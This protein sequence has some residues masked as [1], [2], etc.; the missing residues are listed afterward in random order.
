MIKIN[1][2]GAAGA[3]IMLL[4]VAYLSVSHYVVMYADNKAYQEIEEQA[5]L[6]IELANQTITEYCGVTPEE[7]REEFRKM[8]ILLY[9]EY[10]HCRSYWDQG[11]FYGEE[12][13]CSDDF[14]GERLQAFFNL[15]DN[16]QCK[17]VVPEE[18]TLPYE[19]LW[20][21]YLE[22]PMH[23]DCERTVF[24][25]LIEYDTLGNFAYQ[26][27][28]R[29]IIPS[30][31]CLTYTID[32]KFYDRIISKINPQDNWKDYLKVNSSTNFDNADI[33]VFSE[34]D[35][36]GNIGVLGDCKAHNWGKK[37]ILNFSPVM[38]S[39]LKEVPGDYK[40]I[41]KP[42]T[43]NPFEITTSLS[44]STYYHFSTKK[45]DNFT[46]D[47]V[48]PECQYIFNLD[49]YNNDVSIDIS[50]NPYQTQTN[51]S[52]DPFA[53]TSNVELTYTVNNNNNEA[54]ENVDVEII[55]NDKKIK[56]T[57]DK[58]EAN[59]NY[60]ITELA[61]IQDG[62]IA[63]TRAYTKSMKSEINISNNIEEAYFSSKAGQINFAPEI[64]VEDKIFI[65]A[66]ELA[67]I[68]PFIKDK[69][70]DT[71][72]ISYSSLFNENGEWQTTENDAGTYEIEITASDG[73]L[74]NKKSL[75]VSV[76]DFDKVK[77]IEK[78][79]NSEKSIQLSNEGKTSFTFNQNDE[80]Y[81]AKI[82]VSN[83][84]TCNISYPFEYEQVSDKTCTEENCQIECRYNKECIPEPY[85]PDE[86]EIGY[87][88]DSA[89]CYR[90]CERAECIENYHEVFRTS[91]TIN[92]GSLVQKPRAYTFKDSSNYCYSLELRDNYQGP[93]NYEYRF[94]NLYGDF[95][96]EILEG[97]TKT[98]MTNFEIEKCDIDCELFDRDCSNDC[99]GETLLLEPEILSYSP[100]SNYIWT[101]N[102]SILE[103]DKR[104]E[105]RENSCKVGD[106]TTSTCDISIPEDFNLL[107]ND[108][109][110]YHAQTL[111]E[112]Q[113]IDITNE[114]K[115][116]LSNCLIENCIIELKVESKNAADIN[117]SSPQII[118]KEQ[119]LINNIPKINE[120]L[121]YK[122]L[123]L[124]KVLL[125]P[126][127]IS[128]EYVIT[129]GDKLEIQIK[130]ED[131][132]YDTLL[133]ETN[134]TNVTNPNST[135]T[136]LRKNI[137]MTFDE[138]FQG[139]YELNFKVSDNK[140][141]T[142]EKLRLNVNKQKPKIGYINE[143]NSNNKET[144]FTDTTNNGICYSLSITEN[145]PESLLV[146]EIYNPDN[147]LINSIKM[148]F[149]SH[150]KTEELIEQE[151]IKYLKPGLYNFK[152]FENEELIDS[153][154]F[155]KSGEW[156]YEDQTFNLSN[157][158][159]IEY[160]LTWLERDYK[161]TSFTN[162]AL[163]N[164]DI[165]LIYRLKLNNK[166]NIPFYYNK[167]QIY[168][169]SETDSFKRYMY[170]E[171]DYTFRFVDLAGNEII[172]DISVRFPEMSPKLPNSIHTSDV[173][174]KPYDSRNSILLDG[175]ISEKNQVYM[176][177]WAAKEEL[178]ED[179]NVKI[180]LICGSDIDQR[181]ISLFRMH[182]TRRSAGIAYFTNEKWVLGDNCQ[183][184][185]Y[186]NKRLD[187]IEYFTYGETTAPPP[188][189]DS[190]ILKANQFANIIYSGPTTTMNNYL[191]QNKDIEKMFYFDPTTQQFKFGINLES[192]TTFDGDITLEN[193]MP[194][195]VQ[196]K[197]NTTMPMPTKTTNEPVD[198]I[199]GFNMVS[200]FGENSIDATK[201]DWTDIES[202]FYFDEDNQQFKFVIKLEDNSLFGQLTIVP[203]KHYFVRAN[204]NTSFKFEE[205]TTNNQAPRN[206]AINKD[207][208]TLENFSTVKV[209]DKQKT[210][211][212]NS[213]PSYK[214]V[215]EKIISIC[216]TNKGKIVPKYDENGC[217]TKE[218]CKI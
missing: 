38:D 10:K 101:W 210:T 13:E 127:P 70:N 30:N 6:D 77:T 3:I 86:R 61:S 152:L 88:C 141:I 131:K 115:E 147:V 85:F 99:Y 25:D 53:P 207:N 108:K 40:V 16:Y 206:L 110:I 118:Y 37:S 197:Q 172:E 1:E 161:T 196:A 189:E 45:A 122:E 32:Y 120:I 109:V 21:L 158:S 171:S 91:G 148:A 175:E 157:D 153:V 178:P 179:T 125:K 213:C 165:Q 58:I 5:K 185:I 87:S 107:L 28:K 9:D 121:V 84:N 49:S 11:N 44:Y 43:N 39:E 14:L 96:N 63:Y 216:E 144:S 169:E 151:N 142:T 80:I 104:G 100:I 187:H 93:K 67:K 89:N 132:D 81:F 218:V 20:E 177:G 103:A 31:N 90:V 174:F 54:I 36:T 126:D 199:T 60:K 22:M 117:L 215:S 192:G 154:N 212:N 98:Y 211:E 65:N 143:C 124:E 73:K 163:A 193:N 75:L 205:I 72:T 140:D 27:P 204:K 194:L 50:T 167:G 135:T 129:Q 195:L 66:G 82:N 17:G 62:E 46:I 168:Y 183:I 203:N 190:Y 76:L 8:S 52:I 150:T 35:E 170:P 164:S 26:I 201:L 156:N 114:V 95:A 74:S 137:L 51:Y 79:S 138:S 34:I 191:K 116:A 200:F 186:V 68:E 133:Y 23:E 12:G 29:K 105:Q 111:E 159:T 198:L 106:T 19:N 42:K 184:E 2:K 123:G 136:D 97:I 202:V 24:L 64:I 113:E 71:T 176:F 214:K 160:N 182:G 83:S 209:I 55:L 162:T 149:N 134:I 4:V 188:S 47:D 181:D 145:I 69:E 217:I 15:Y 180:K 94:N 41:I 18:Y 139:L 48:A 7:Y 59:D 33:I 130:A 166:Y 102:Y 57:I 208:V 56:K 146:G 78:F 128:G 112:L 119:K 173:Y 155:T 92:N